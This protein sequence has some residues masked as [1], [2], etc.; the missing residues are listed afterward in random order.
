MPASCLRRDQT[1]L[2]SRLMPSQS[3]TPGTTAGKRSCPPSLRHFFLADS[4]EWRRHRSRHG[5]DWLRPK[6][7]CL[8]ARQAPSPRNLT[9]ALPTLSNSLQCAIRDLDGGCLPPPEQPPAIRQGPIQNRLPHQTGQ[10]PG[11]MPE[12]QIQNIVDRLNAPIPDIR[13]HCRAT[14]RAVMQFAQSQLTAQSTPR[15][16]KHVLPVTRSAA[17]Y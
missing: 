7:P 3:S 5:N 10:H 12:R 8:M 2:M 1:A 13:D 9:P 14:E 17:T 16:C 15:T 4:N 6:S 11:R